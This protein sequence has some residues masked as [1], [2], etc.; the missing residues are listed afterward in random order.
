[1]S[2]DQLV[3]ALASWAQKELTSPAHVKVA[4]RTRSSKIS[5]AWATRRSVEALWNSVLRYRR[6]PTRLRRRTNLRGNSLSQRC[7]VM[8]LSALF[9]NQ[10]IQRCQYASRSG[11][12][13]GDRGIAESAARKTE[14]VRKPEPKNSLKNIFPGKRM[15]AVAGRTASTSQFS[16]ESHS[17][18]SSS[19]DQYFGGAGMWT[20]ALV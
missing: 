13:L 16:P 12:F 2:P 20:S 6:R 17:T 14:R 18:N 19:S 4:G 8:S 15:T 10:P 1:V 5:A 11:R 7:S 3:S 9:L